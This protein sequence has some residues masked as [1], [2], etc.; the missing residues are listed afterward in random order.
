MIEEIINQQI[1]DPGKIQKSIIRLAKLVLPLI[2]T[3]FFANE[4]FN[5]LIIE[6]ESILDL[7]NP[8]AFWKYLIIIFI[9][10]SCYQIIFEVIPFIA[11]IPL[12]LLSNWIGKKLDTYS[13]EGIEI[14]LWIVSQ[15]NLVKFNI[16]TSRLSPG[17]KTDELYESI[18]NDSTELSNELESNRT[19]ELCWITMLFAIGYIFQPYFDSFWI[20]LFLGVS[21]I[22]MIYFYI[23]QKVMHYFFVN[24]FLSLKYISELLMHEKYLIDGLNGFNF[25]VNYIGKR[26][27]LINTPNE[28]IVFMALTHPVILIDNIEFIYSLSGQENMRH[29]VFSNSPIPTPEYLNVNIQ[30]VKFT[31][32]ISL[33][34]QIQDTLVTLVIEYSQNNNAPQLN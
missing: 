28:Q 27:Y 3:I 13:S 4:V 31:D 11:F 26:G 21:L 12:Q 7:L 16:K 30:I 32:L 34:K 15:A 1:A 29:I 18:V 25:D 8:K 17:F 9:Y 5:P 24:K 6:I 23:V 14:F 20:E 2:P 33:E 10:A 19:A 22:S